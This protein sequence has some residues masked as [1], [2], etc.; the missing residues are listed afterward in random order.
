MKY[1]AAYMLAALNEE[2]SPSKAAM[3]KILESVGCEIKGN[4]GVI[5]FQTRIIDLHLV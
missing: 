5:L 3:T 4:R 2:A 1:V